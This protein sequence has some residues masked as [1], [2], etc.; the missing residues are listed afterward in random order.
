MCNAN[1]SEGFEPQRDVS[2]PEINIPV[3]QLGP[4]SLVQRPSRRTIFAFFAGGAHGHVRK[5]LF[6]HWKEKDEEIQVHEYLPK[7]Q[8]YF[9]M[10]GKSKFCL[11]PSGYEVASPRVIEA[12]YAECVPVIIKD[13]Y[14]FPFS[15]VLDWTQFSIH[16]PVVRI[17]DI[18]K[19]LKGV[20]PIEYS[21]L[22]KG[23]RAVRRHFTLNR[24]AKPFDLFHMILHSIWLRRL[25]FRLP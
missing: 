17:P 11:C 8:N 25:N 22:L 9:Q 20:S 24:P 1:I 23:V 15:D 21:K 18:K 7:G 2:I 16:V 5:F 6:E 19:I 13:N 10:L 3:G 14:S 4:P 12:I